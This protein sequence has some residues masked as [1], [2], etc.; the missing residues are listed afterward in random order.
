LGLR[1]GL[2]LPR[3]RSHPVVATWKPTL[4][5]RTCPGNLNPGVLL[6]LLLLI[7]IL[8]LISDW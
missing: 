2:A 6:L 5:P 1:P 3:D 7:L 4:S 8:I